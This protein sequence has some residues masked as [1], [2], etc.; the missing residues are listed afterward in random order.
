[1]KPVWRR[2]CQATP[3]HT[4]DPSTDGCGLMR[5]AYGKD[6][7]SVVR[8]NGTGPDDGSIMDLGNQQLNTLI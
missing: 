7:M 2:Y 6:H 1:M 4:R 5:D 8:W 3:L